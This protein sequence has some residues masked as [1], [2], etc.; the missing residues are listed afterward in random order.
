LPQVRLSLSQLAQYNKYMTKN[1]LLK[2]IVLAFSFPMLAS[3]QQGL[4]QLPPT[5]GVANVSGSVEEIILRYINIAL[6]IV[7]VLVVAF[8]IYGG[9]LYITSGGN[10]E[11]AERGKKVITNAIIGLVII[12]FSFVIVNVII[13]TLAN[14][15]T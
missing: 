1:K 4:H 9:F 13:N 11:S 6:S 8:L 12:I 2:I 14:R 3:A 5:G 7:A 15:I 10:E